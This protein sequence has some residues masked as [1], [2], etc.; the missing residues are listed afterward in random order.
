MSRTRGAYMI[1]PTKDDLR[2]DIKNLITQKQKLNGEVQA[3]RN[4]VLELT[5]ERDRACLLLGRHLVKA[6]SK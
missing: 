2:R 6:Q 5:A 3:L 1:Q 4:E